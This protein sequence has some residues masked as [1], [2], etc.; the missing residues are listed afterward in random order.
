VNNSVI[1]RI[2]KAKHDGANVYIDEENILPK[3]DYYRVE[4]T[5]LAITKD[6][7][8]NIQGNFEPK[9]EVLD[10]VAEANGIIFT[11]GEVI[12][13]QIIDGLYTDKDGKPLP[14]TVYIGRADGKRV[15]TDGAEVNSGIMEYELDPA[16]R[17]IDDCTGATIYSPETC[18]K[19]KTAKGQTM[20]KAFMTYSKYGRQLANT[21]A[22]NR[23]IRKLV[24]MP[25]AF[26][27]ADL[28]K[29][30]LFARI[31][32]NLQAIA[33]TPQG[34]ILAASKA[35]NLDISSVFGAKKSDLISSLQTPAPQIGIQETIPP[36]EITGNTA[37]TTAN[38]AA[39]AAAPEEPDFPDEPTGPGSPQQEKTKF[40]RLTEGLQEF[41]EGFQ[42][43]L[44]ITSHNGRNPYKLAEAELA[45][46][47]ATE[48]TRSSMIERLRNYLKAKGIDV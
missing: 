38:L 23:V 42:A 28:N 9:N 1:T 21:R 35:L 37:S 36:E 11:Y 47:T 25:I 17:A 19:F 44:D 2:Q 8:Y 32:P 34:A 48:E 41:I 14:R 20:A 13:R 15:I 26:K 33:S 40:D 7:C 18:G 29:V 22:R 46:P 12:Q 10:Q 45:D 5:E 16:I 4:M 24:G 3:T 6:N 30:F 31:V 39:E 27:D 43:E